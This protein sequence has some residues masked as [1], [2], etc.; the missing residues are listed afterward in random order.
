MT[1]KRHRTS[2]KLDFAE[3]QDQAMAAPLLL[4]AMFTLCQMSNPQ[5]GFKA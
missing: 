5:T 4:T 3:A 2:Y 1:L